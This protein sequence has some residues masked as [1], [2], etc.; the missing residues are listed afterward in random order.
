MVRTCSTW[1]VHGVYMV[2]TWCF[3]IERVIFD[4]Y[5]IL[6]LYTCVSPDKRVFGVPL[7]VNVR[8]TGQALPPVIY[9]AM[10]YL[11]T[12][13]RMELLGLFR[14]AA[15]KARVEIL[16]EVAESDP[17]KCEALYAFLK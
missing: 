17:G 9:H 14:R 6:M 13:D 5:S 16:K 15:S 10:D 2:C 7:S 12:D 11:R 3:Q 4:M 8:T 1:C